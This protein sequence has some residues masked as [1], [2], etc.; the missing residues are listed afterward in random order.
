MK[1]ILSFVVGMCLVGAVWFAISAGYLHIPASECRLWGQPVCDK[2]GTIYT[3][4]CEAKNAGISVEN[5]EAKEEFCVQTTT[6]QPPVLTTHYSHG[7]IGF[8]YPS[9]WKI[10]S[11]KT[12]STYTNGTEWYRT[13]FAKSEGKNI[14]RFEK[15][16]DGYGP[17]GWKKIYTLKYNSNGS[18]E[19]GTIEEVNPWEIPSQ[20]IDYAVRFAYNNEN[21][22]WMFASDNANDEIL[23][24]AFLKSI[25][26][27]KEVWVAPLICPSEKITQGTYSFCLPKDHTWKRENNILQLSHIN[28]EDTISITE[29]S[30]KSY[31]NS[32]TKF[33]D[34]TIA[35]NNTTQ[36]WELDERK[37]TASQWTRLST[38]T[39]KNGTKVFIGTERWLTYIVPIDEWHLVI[40]NSTGGWFVEPLK[41]LIE[42]FTPTS[43]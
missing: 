31:T 39:T 3:N 32:D 2:N 13:D 27:K 16:P 43:R 42:S 10:A 22:V 12:I 23:F 35:Y 25:T 41:E 5:G 7:T 26:V 19:V 33:W 38:L 29:F 24:Q 20:V 6:Q 17:F 34:I 18:V 1:Y 8:D 4:R 9:E 28:T 15:N 11:E 40:L 30:G 37:R 36:T 21:Y 14:L